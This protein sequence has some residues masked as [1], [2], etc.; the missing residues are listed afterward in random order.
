MDSTLTCS[1]LLI[2]A[3]HYLLDYQTTSS[4]WTICYTVC[5]LVVEAQPS[6]LTVVNTYTL[7]IVMTISNTLTHR[8]PYYNYISVLIYL[9]PEIH[10]Y[11]VKQGQRKILI[12][13]EH[14]DQAKVLFLVQE[15]LYRVLKF[16]LPQTLLRNLQYQKM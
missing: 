11:T 4:I 8:I 5:P 16:T 1:S 13:G 12:V 2:P 10:T 7:Y 9:L 15:F 6:G 3:P 14:V